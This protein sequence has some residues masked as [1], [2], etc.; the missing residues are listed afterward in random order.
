MSQFQS[1]INSLYNPETAHYTMAE[2]PQHI[3]I[4]LLLP[5]FLSADNENTIV[6][7]QSVV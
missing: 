1:Q 2:L 6:L 4:C 7:L 5:T 3:S